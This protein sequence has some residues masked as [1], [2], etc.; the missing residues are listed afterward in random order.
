MSTSPIGTLGSGAQ[1]DGAR[2]KSALGKDEFVKLLMTQLGNQ[3]PTSPM[4]NQAFVAQLAQFANVELLQGANARLDTMA[5]ATASTNQTL[6]AS[7]VGKEVQYR[8]DA[9]RLQAGTPATMKAA[10]AGSATEVTAVVMDAT[11][12]PVRTLRLGAQPEGPLSLTWDGRDDVG[13]PQPP[14]D[15]TVRITA[16]DLAGKSVSVSQRSSGTV[17]AVSFEQGYPELLIGNT[18]LK[19]SDVVEIHQAPPAA[20]P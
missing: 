16:A 11:G 1:A 20:T 4:D 15:Y 7:L 8:S 13:Q 12:K 18:R 9:V 3:D 14:G 5:L 2:D 6:A 19:M 10:L 17:S